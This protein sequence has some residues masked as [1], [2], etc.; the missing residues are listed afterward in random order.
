MTVSIS[1]L[2]TGYC[3]KCYVLIYNVI[4]KTAQNRRAPN[5]MRQPAAGAACCWCILLWGQPA[6]GAACCCNSPLLEQPEAGSASPH[7][8]CQIKTVGSARDIMT[9]CMYARTCPCI[10]RPVGRRGL[11]AW[12]T[13]RGACGAERNPILRRRRSTVS[14]GTGAPLPA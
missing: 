1:T 3:K 13:W 6:A 12:G 10:A 2:V 7:A 14:W 9:A 4:R 11:N 8:R 5:K